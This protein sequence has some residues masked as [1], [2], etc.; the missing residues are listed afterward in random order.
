MPHRLTKL[1]NSRACRSVS[2]VLLMCFCDGTV[3]CSSLCRW[4]ILFLGR[5][6]VF[7]RLILCSTL[8]AST[9]TCTRELTKSQFEKREGATDDGTP[10]GSGHREAYA[11]LQ[12]I[13]CFTE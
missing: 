13:I 5:V 2:G 7:Q 10:G 4:G 8:M 9:L 3:F 12:V 6:C 11:T 1:G